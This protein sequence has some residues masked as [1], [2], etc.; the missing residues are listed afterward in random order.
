[1]SFFGVRRIEVSGARYLTPAAVVERMA[2]RADASVFDDLD[3]VE[4]RLESQSGVA[5]A[6]V[7]RRLPATIVVEVT[8]VEPVALA[9]GPDGLV[10]LAQDARPLP[11]DVVTAVVDAPI[12][13]AADRPLL[14]GLALVQ[15]TDLGLYGDVVSA[16]VSGAE[17]VLDMGGGRVRLRMPVEPEVVRS[18]SSVRRD[19][20][21]RGT[22]WRELDGRF[23]GWIV[24]RK[25]EA[26]AVGRARS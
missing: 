4:T 26:P 1:M 22:D 13:R 16:R 2:L 6:T 25:P 19:L 7:S 24:V 20:R 18:I 9:D 17:I 3:V 8:E 11:Y 5:Q 10:A 15:A 21:S 12:V 23:K 14:E